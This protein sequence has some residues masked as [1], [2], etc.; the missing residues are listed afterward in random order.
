MQRIVIKNFGP[1]KD[2]DI[3][4]HDFMI[5]IGPQASGKSTIAKL[6]Y[7]FQELPD[8]IR[9]SILENSDEN[10]KVTN[11][12]IYTKIEAEII[13]LIN[14]FFSGTNIDNFKIEYFYN[15][16]KEIAISIFVKDEIH[17]F[18][19]PSLKKVF[20]QL[21]SNVRL[22]RNK[23]LRYYPRILDSPSVSDLVDEF[24]VKTFMW[25]RR[26][27][28]IPAGR[29]IFSILANQFLISDR[30]T[31]AHELK[32][33]ALEI[34]SLRKIYARNPF[35]QK[36]IFSSNNAEVLLSEKLLLKILKGA[37]SFQRKNDIIEITEK[38]FVYIENASSGQQ[39]AL[40]ILLNLYDN[41]AKQE[42]RFY[43]IEEPEAHL[44]PEAQKY[45]SEL[46]ALSANKKGNNI[47]ITTHSPYILSA[48]NN[49]LYANEVGK[50]HPE[51]VEKVV[52]KNLWL[53]YDRIMA[54][55]VDEGKVRS[56]MDEELRLIKSEEIDSASRIINEEYNKL[57][58]IEFSK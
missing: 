1:V 32:E 30:D 19:S 6:I 51:Q 36:T 16:Q 34:N 35:K 14:N 25:G 37:Y 8:I 49:L 26:N 50:T 42:L 56:I 9:N 41:I 10:S 12:L 45:I 23:S 17:V 11:E 38:D 40:W 13:N 3:P 20:D 44:Y 47:I 18:Y 22:R 24:I 31:V 43:I 54:Y 5:F 52:D 28:F 2:V 39:E 58:D 7:F 53:D 4:I 55:F 29:S 33:Y 48:I 21:I 27:T 57:S 46:I 15:D